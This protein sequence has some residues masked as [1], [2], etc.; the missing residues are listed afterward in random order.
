LF[1]SWL[2]CYKYYPVLTA[3]WLVLGIKM[4]VEIFEQYTQ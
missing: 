3:K 1:V 4:L 2:S